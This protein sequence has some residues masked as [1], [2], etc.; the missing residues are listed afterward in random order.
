MRSADDMYVVL[1]L[2][3]SILTSANSIIFVRNAS[4]LVPVQIPQ[5]VYCLVVI[6]A[7][8][9]TIHS[10]TD[11]MIATSECIRMVLAFAVTTSHVASQDNLKHLFLN[12]N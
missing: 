6:V 12:F 3:K 9:M 5:N 11:I 2:Q 4:L 1:Y 8:D 10:V 7:I